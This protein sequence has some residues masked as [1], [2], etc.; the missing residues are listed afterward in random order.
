MLNPQNLKS[1]V[2][3]DPRWRKNIDVWFIK[4]T[5]KYFQFKI[6]LNYE[7]EEIESLRKQQEDEMEVMRKQRRNI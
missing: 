3:T 2:E 4:K 6:W 5:K 1:F 7:F